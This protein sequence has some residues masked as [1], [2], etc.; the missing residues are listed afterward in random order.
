MPAPEAWR[1]T[2]TKTLLLKN[3]VLLLEGGVEPTH[4]FDLRRDRVGSPPNTAELNTR[5]VALMGGRGWLLER[6]TTYIWW[7]WEGARGGSWDGRAGVDT[8]VPAVVRDVSPFF[9]VSMYSG[10]GDVIPPLQD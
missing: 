7:G 4:S 3:R 8:R 2:A 10:K 6:G 5:C 1:W 9:R